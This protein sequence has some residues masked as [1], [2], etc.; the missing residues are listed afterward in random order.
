MKITTMKTIALY[1]GEWVVTIIRNNG[2]AKEYRFEVEADAR[3]F[4]AS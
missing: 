4:L 3:R 1:L 2:D